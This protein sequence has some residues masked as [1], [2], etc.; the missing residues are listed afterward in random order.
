MA[1][2]PI[3]QSPGR[4]KKIDTFTYDLVTPL[5]TDKATVELAVFM[6]K[7]FD[8]D[9]P[10]L[11]VTGVEFMI[12]CADPEFEVKGTDL[13]LLLTTARSRL[14]KH[15]EISWER[16]IKVQI[17]PERPYRGEGTGFRLTYEDVW[18]GV[19][20]FGNALM[21]EYDRHRERLWTISRWPE[22]FKDRNGRT[23]ACV[24][25]TEA[26]VAALEDFTK[27]IDTLRS[28]LA[29][30]VSPDRITET[31]DAIAAGAMP[32]LPSSTDA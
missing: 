15:Y 1:R 29:D 21:R 2:T 30:F 26:N 23:L 18:R 7:S 24:P 22:T 9:E 3:R 27:R 31:L 12:V 6:N 13:H 28:L 5:G 19:D 25:A 14:D 17:T 32:L 8:G 16:W 20:A 4:G 11:A 10:P